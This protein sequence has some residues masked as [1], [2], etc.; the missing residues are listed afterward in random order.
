M[1]LRSLLLHPEATITCTRR[2]SSREEASFQ[3]RNRSEAGCK[4]I[5]PNLSWTWQPPAPR[6]MRLCS[7]WQSQ[8]PAPHVMRLAQHWRL[9]IPPQVWHFFVPKRDF[10][11]FAPCVWGLQEGR[12]KQ[13]E[14]DRATDR[15]FGRENGP[16]CS[17]K[18]SQSNPDS[19]FV[20]RAF[21]GGGG[22]G[23][24]LDPPSY[25]LSKSRHFSR[26]QYKQQTRR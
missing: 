24:V 3:E 14:A 12:Q 22:G 8:S 11:G 9:P 6:V 23:I 4:E 25:P 18:K 2:C 15:G 19:N 21:W 7:T 20:D 16:G 17:H 13:T 1:S 10:L 5:L 26:P